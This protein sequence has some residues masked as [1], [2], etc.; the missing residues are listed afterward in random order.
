[1]KKKHLIHPKKKPFFL[2][3]LKKMKNSGLYTMS[4]LTML[5]TLLKSKV[6]ALCWRKNSIILEYILSN[7][8]QNGQLRIFQ[9]LMIFYLSKAVSIVTIG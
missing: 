9:N 1:M 5:M 6:L 3:L 4:V 2:H 8:F 7:R